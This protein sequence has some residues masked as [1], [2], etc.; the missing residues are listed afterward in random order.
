MY[1]STY[2]WQTPIYPVVCD[3]TSLDGTPLYAGTLASKLDLVKLINYT[4]LELMTSTY[5]MCIIQTVIIERT[6]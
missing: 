6:P 2:L 3:P 4:E 1:I 5:N